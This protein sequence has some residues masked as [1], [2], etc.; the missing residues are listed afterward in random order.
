MDI[1]EFKTIFCMIDPVKI[2]A[3]FIFLVAS[4]LPSSL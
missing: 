1:W 3:T 4:A 2:S